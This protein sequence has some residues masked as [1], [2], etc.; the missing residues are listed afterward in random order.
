[1]KKKILSFMLALTMITAFM[2]IIASA[3]T[4]GTCGENLTWELDA[5][6]TLTISGNGAMT[7][8]K[9]WEESPFYRNSNITSI[10]F[11]NGITSIDSGAFY[12]CDKLKSV[13]MPNSITD[14][15]CC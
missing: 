10:I 13:R 5:A 11:E 7:D 8:Y 6:G 15:S 1:M 12:G 9:K 4:S 2:P 14:I 3:E